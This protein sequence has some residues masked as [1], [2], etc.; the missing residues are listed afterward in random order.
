MIQNRYYIRERIESQPYTRRKLISFF[1][2]MAMIKHDLRVSLLGMYMIKQVFNNEIHDK[3]IY[4]Q[5]DMSVH[6]H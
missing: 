4:T 6:A 5:S 1:P 2:H 3:P